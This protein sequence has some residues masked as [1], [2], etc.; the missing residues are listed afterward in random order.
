MV[1]QW[2]KEAGCQRI[3]AVSN[4]TGEG[5]DELRDYLLKIPKRRTLE[6]AKADQQAGISS[7]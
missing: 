6:E 3:F 2:L 5:I 1:T 7:F 4:E